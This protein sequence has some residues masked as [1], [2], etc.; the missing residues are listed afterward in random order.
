MLYQTMLGPGARPRRGARREPVACGLNAGL[1]ARRLS[2]QWR[3][4]DLGSAVNVG[5]DPVLLNPRTPVVDAVCASVCGDWFEAAD[6]W[7]E[8]YRDPRFR[9]LAAQCGAEASLYAGLLDL[10]EYF[11]LGFGDR[12]ALPPFL[13]A[14]RDKHAPIRA[15]R[16][17]YYDRGRRGGTAG[18]GV[19]GEL[20][21]L[22][23]YREAIRHFLVMPPAERDSPATVAL[24][25]RAYAMLGAHASLIALHETR[26]E[27]LDHAHLGPMVDR[28]RRL[29]ARQGDPPARNMQRFEQQHPA[30][31]LFTELTRKAAGARR[32]EAPP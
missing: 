32:A 22:H 24:L 3:P 10:A 8:V 18:T 27:I 15:A 11:Y 19:G 26:G 7:F 30:G 28:A 20:M 5:L 12:A 2:A 23:F 21:R 14:L 31:A 1:T 25:T 9:P 16:M 13:G 17:A 4:A 6:L 29:L